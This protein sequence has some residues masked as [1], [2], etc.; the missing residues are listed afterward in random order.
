M[1]RLP[2]ITVLLFLIL[3]SCAKKSDIDTTTVK[4]LDLNRYMGTWYEIA[5]FPH[6][7]END[8]VGVTANYRLRDDGKI[9]VLNSGWKGTLE[10]EY[11]AADGVAKIPD[12][13]DPAKLKVSFFLFFYADYYIL[14]LDTINYQYALIGSSDPNYLWILGRQPQMD[15]KL[16]QKLVNEAARRGYDTSKLYKVPQPEL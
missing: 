16:Y 4:S 2:I 13:S 3:T 15:P 1:T 12:P 10:G 7:F 11:D 14:D 6:S 5:R 8:L 9:R